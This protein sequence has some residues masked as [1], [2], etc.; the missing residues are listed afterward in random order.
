[1]IDRKVEIPISDQ[2]KFQGEDREQDKKETEE[3][4]F[5]DGERYYTKEEFFNPPE[6]KEDSQKS[7]KSYHWLKITVAFLLTV[8][9]LGNVLSLWPQLFNFVSVEFLSI[10]KELSQD[11]NVQL[12]K[13]SVVVVRTENSKGTGFYISEDGYVMTNQHVID[14]GIQITVTFQEGDTYIADVVVSDE[15]IDIDILQLHSIEEEYQELQF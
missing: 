13:E 10:S 14:G 6:E 5:F 9:L 4:L 12:Y 7:K 8:A 2:D 11:E 15:D 3:Q 1:E